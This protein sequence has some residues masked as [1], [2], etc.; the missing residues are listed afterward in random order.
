MVVD[1]AEALEVRLVGDAQPQVFV[2]ARCQADQ[3]DLCIQRLVQKRVDA[4]LA[5]GDRKTRQRCEQGYQ[6]Q[7]A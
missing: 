7:W 6:Q 1:D 5:K 4:C 2:L 3:V